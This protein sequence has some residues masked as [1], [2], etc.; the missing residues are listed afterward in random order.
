MYKKYSKFR[1]SIKSMF[2]EQGRSRTGA[3]LGAL[4]VVGRGEH[5][6]PLYDNMHP[7]RC[8]T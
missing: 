3:P 1:T 4:T 8:A 2:I 7:K 5:S 6:E